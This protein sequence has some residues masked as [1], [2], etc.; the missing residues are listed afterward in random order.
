MA[1]YLP[2]F[3]LS[4]VVFPGEKLNLHV[5]EPRYRQLVLDCVEDKNT[6]GIPTYIQNGVGLYG[7]EVRLVQIEKKYDS[8]EIDIRTEGI[9]VFKLLQFDKT[10]PAKMYAGGELETVPQI[11]DEDLVMKQNITALLHELYEALGLSKLSVEL[12][13]NYK[14]FSIAHELGLTLEQEYAL[15]QLKRESAR[16][17]LV[18]QHLQQT[19]PVVQ[20]TEQLKDR[21]RLNG[22]FKN[23]LPPN[24]CAPLL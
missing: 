16:Q 17:E 21:V 5:F 12:P 7:T 18:L 13:E 19:L 6:F 24:F 11:D 23:L 20:Q 14:I 10:A 1:R 2:L 15:L 22:H 3:P 9:E 8:G 4:I